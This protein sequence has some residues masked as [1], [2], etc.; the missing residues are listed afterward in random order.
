MPAPTAAPDPDPVETRRR[1]L[2]RWENEGG[3][4]PPPDSPAHQGAPDLTNTEI[5]HLRIRLIALE[6]V[7][8]AVLAQ[9]SE[10]QLQVARQMAGYIC[11]RPGFTCHPLTI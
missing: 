1:A 8:I 11:P 3:A 4:I 7:L 10:K 9:G 6:N 5:V 2:S